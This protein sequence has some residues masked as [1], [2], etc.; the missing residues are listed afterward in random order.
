MAG[1]ID[2]NI[3]KPELAT[4]FATGYQQAQQTR[5]QNEMNQID[6]DKLKQDRAMLIDLQA[7]LRAIGQSDDPNQFF[8]AMIQTGN[9]DYMA[10]G[11]EGLQRYRELQRAE[12]LLRKEAPELFGPESGVVAPAAPTA[13]VNALAPSVA[14]APAPT[15]ALAAP[16]APAAPVAPA[17]ALT[18][19]GT[20]A[21]ELRNKILT[22]R[23]LNDPR[24]KAM[25]DV[26]QAELNELVKPQ[27]VGPN[28][29]VFRGGQSVFT[30]PAAPT[31][32]QRNYEFAKKQGFKGSLFDYERQLKEAGRAPA[33]P[34]PEQPP[35]AVIDPTTGKQVFVSREEALSKR[36][37]PAAAQEGLTPKEIQKREAKY[38][39]ATATIKTFEDKQGQLADD[40]DKLAAHPGLSG[41]S[42]LIYGRTPAITGEARQAEALYKNIAARG[43][44]GE[45]AAIRQA[46]PT[47]GALG[48]VSNQEGQYLRDAFAAIDKTQN[49]KDLAAALRKA[50]SQVR[51]SMA[52]VREA[53]D[54]TYEYRKGG[55]PEKAA[56][57]GVDANNPLLK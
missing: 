47:G 43:Q 9:P 46:S 22:Y 2:V 48:N 41:I 29:T 56:S 23:S 49:T 40:L 21:Q 26:Y 4:S 25:A 17:N 39:Q 5:Q 34:R 33:Q 53:Y 3:L 8:K 18:A 6:L 11:Y 31:E 24:L 55:A 36:M 52:N 15:N 44:F 20:R 19:P 27:V 54:L 1:L 50:A 16:A 10:K 37:T 51:S 12:Q 35:V 42:G 7:K 28:S 57:G 38:P 30:A 32:L 13:P 14:A 45:L